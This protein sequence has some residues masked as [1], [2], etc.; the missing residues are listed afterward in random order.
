MPKKVTFDFFSNSQFVDFSVLRFCLQWSISSV[1]NFKMLILHDQYLCLAP[2]VKN[3]HI[4]SRAEEIFTYIFCMFAVLSL[5]V[6]FSTI[7]VLSKYWPFGL[8]SATLCRSV[9]AA[10]CFS[11]YL[12]SF[13]I[14]AIALDRHRSI[15][16]ST[17]AQLTT[18]MVREP[19]RMNGLL[20]Y[21]CFVSRIS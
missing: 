19:K 10:P 16:N 7:S 11:V 5:T 20:Q 13:T 14:M 21:L 15:V 9:K 3:I 8:D 18:K 17:K 12:S 4:P 1:N 6:I 2:E